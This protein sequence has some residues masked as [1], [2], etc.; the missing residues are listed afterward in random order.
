MWFYI[1]ELVKICK[2]KCVQKWFQKLR[3]NFSIILF[4]SSQ[5]QSNFKKII[6]RNSIVLLKK[7]IKFLFVFNTFYL[8]C[9]QFSISR[10]VIF[11]T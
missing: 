10:K 6:D 8:I 5:I 3:L 9:S 4:Y 7:N 2:K 1:F 11:V